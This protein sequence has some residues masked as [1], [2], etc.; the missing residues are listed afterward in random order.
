MMALPSDEL[1][2]AAFAKGDRQ[3]FDRLTARY[4]GEFDAFSRR[5]LP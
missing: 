5:R 4:S 3:V 2:L 1:P